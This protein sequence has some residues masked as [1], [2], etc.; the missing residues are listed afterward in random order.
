MS[1]TADIECPCGTVCGRYR[2]PT[3]TDD[4]Y[5]EGLGENFADADGNWYCSQECLDAHTKQVKE[6]P[7][8]G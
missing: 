4:G 6:N 8:N 3:R 2:Y 7:D 1:L 5:S